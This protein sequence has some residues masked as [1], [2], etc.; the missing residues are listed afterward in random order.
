[1]YAP[2]KSEVRK[3]E[4]IEFNQVQCMRRQTHA[5]MQLIRQVLFERKLSPNTSP[6]ENCLRILFF[7]MSKPNHGSRK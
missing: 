6:N 1:M 7:N 5:R 4:Q 2:T 3:N